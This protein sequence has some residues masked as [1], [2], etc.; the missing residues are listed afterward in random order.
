MVAL[1][2]ADLEKADAAAAAAS[3]SLYE[4]ATAM[5]SYEMVQQ[6]KRKEVKRDAEQI[7]KL[8]RHCVPQSPAKSNTPESMYAKRLAGYIT[9]D[10]PLFLRL[11]QQSALAY[12]GFRSRTVQLLNKWG[13]EL[14]CEGNLLAHLDSMQSI[15]KWEAMSVSERATLGGDGGP[16]PKP[17]RVALKLRGRYDRLK[18]Q[19]TKYLMLQGQQSRLKKTKTDIFTR[20]KKARTEEKRAAKGNKKRRRKQ[21]AKPTRRTP[22]AESIG[23]GLT[24]EPVHESGDAGRAE[25]TTLGA[26]GATSV[27]QLEPM[28][29]RVE[30]QLKDISEILK[31]AKFNATQ[32]KVAFKS[33]YSHK[34]KA[35]DALTGARMNLAAVQATATTYKLTQMSEY[36]GYEIKRT[37]AILTQLRKFD[38]CVVTKLQELGLT[39]E[40]IK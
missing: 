35:R 30:A 26:V 6:R 12:V 40:Q 10:Q 7:A 13:E 16:F 38:L 14:T 17:T 18:Q 8:I 19:V 24:Q 22:Q 20:L 29:G 37:D 3:S 27:S 11:R 33:L 1:L 39:E 31:K 5:Q 32:Q 23:D 34:R 21:K 36:T 28:L 25:N 9:M 15:E 2:V 4:D